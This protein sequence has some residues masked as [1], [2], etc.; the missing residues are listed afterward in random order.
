M[1]V[2]PSRVVTLS[3]SHTLETYKG[4]GS[5]SANGVGGVVGSDGQMDPTTGA[6]GGPSTYENSSGT[7]DNA[8]GEQVE[9]REQAPGSLTGLHVSVALN[10]ATAA[11]IQPQVIK[12]LVSAGIGIDTKRGDTIDVTALPFDQT[13]ANA[14]KKELADAAAA[15]HK[16]AQ[17]KLIR[18]VGIGGLIAL[19][20]ILA[21]LQA[22]RRAMAREEATE[23]LVEQLR[24]EQA[25]RAALENQPPMPAIE[26]PPVEPE[27]DHIRDELLALVEK[28]P[29]DVAALLRGWLVEPR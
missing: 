16:A 24:S 9:H 1:P 8:V 10:Q 7:Q 22:R 21:W 19:M 11:A 13:T 2:V 14:A 29:E 6:T 17:M 18:N 27:E 4:D 5:A 20:L 28:Q 26:A 15:Q 3:E 23:Y 12:N 25:G